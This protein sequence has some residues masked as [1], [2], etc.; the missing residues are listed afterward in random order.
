MSD[1]A[2]PTE[3][4]AVGVGEET[5]TVE[6]LGIFTDLPQAPIEQLLQKYATEVR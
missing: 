5:T 4:T 2:P 3:A 6:K 1:D